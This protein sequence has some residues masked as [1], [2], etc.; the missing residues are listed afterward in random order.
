[1][2][3]LITENRNYDKQQHDSLELSYMNTL[4]DNTANF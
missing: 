4:Y 2:Y 3:V 1:M